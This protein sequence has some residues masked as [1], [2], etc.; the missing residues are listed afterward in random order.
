MKRALLLS[1]F[2]SIIALLVGCGEKSADQAPHIEGLIYSKDEVSILIIEDIE[3]VDISEAEWQ[4]KPAYSISKT[5]KTKIYDAS[6]KSITFEDLQ[7]GDAVKVWIDGEIMESYPAQAR[8]EKIQ[9][10]K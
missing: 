10:D 1:L 5:D 6:G 2:I 8:A 7:I 9:V 3:S 4:G